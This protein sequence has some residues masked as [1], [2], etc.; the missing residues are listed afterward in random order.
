DFPEDQ[1]GPSRHQAAFEL[2]DLLKDLEQLLASGRRGRVVHA[3]LTVML[4]GAPNVG[5]S[6]L[7]NTLLGEERAIVAPT[8]GTT[9]DL[10]EG[11]LVSQGVPLRLRDGGGLGCA[12]DSIDEVG[13]RRARHAVDQSDLVLLVLDRSRPLSEQDREL[14]RA[15]ASRERIVVANKADL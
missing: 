11:A 1:I 14:V 2:R 12:I 10:V 9:R 13:M 5:K 15:T 6:S 8:P 3:G 7:L 4:T